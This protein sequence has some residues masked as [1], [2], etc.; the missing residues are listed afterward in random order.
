MVGAVAD[1]D[2][3]GHHVMDHRRD[4]AG[5]GLRICRLAGLR[6]LGDAGATSVEY[7]LLAALIAM[8]LIFALQLFGQALS[9]IFNSVGS[10]LS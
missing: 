1:Q 2:M 6:A 7:G 8:G 4:I 5:P 9:D 3:K 10:N